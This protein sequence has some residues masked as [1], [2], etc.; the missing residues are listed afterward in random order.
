[1][2]GRRREQRRALEGMPVQRNAVEISA[3]DQRRRKEVIDEKHESTTDRIRENF[4]PGH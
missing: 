2:F 3:P 4:G 1:M